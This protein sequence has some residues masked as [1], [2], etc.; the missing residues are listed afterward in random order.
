VA[1]D[2]R[3]APEAP[4]PAALHDVL[5]AVDALRD[6]GVSPSLLWLAGDSAGGGLAL[7]TLLAMRDRGQTMPAGALLLSP[8][9]DL[10]DACVDVQMDNEHDYLCTPL[11]EMAREHYVGDVSLTDPL[12]SPVFGDFR[13]LPPLLIQVGGAEI[14]LPQVQR[15][16]ERARAGG[17]EVVLEVQSGMVH[18]FQAF[19]MLLP[20]ARQALRSLGG[21]V[22]HRRRDG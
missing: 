18:V 7:V 22:R 20:E 4:Y 13:G 1:L 5:D 6:Q 16:V 21:F 19:A 3:L 10:T 9:V 12:I 2:Y 8:W 11:L 15:L 17:V 14:F